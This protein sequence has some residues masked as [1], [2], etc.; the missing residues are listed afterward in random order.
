[1][2][3]YGPSVVIPLY[4]VLM[5]V[6]LASTGTRVWIR[7]SQSRDSLGIDDALII[8]G[9][10][11]MVAVNGMQYYNA[12]VGTGGEAVTD[13]DTKAQAVV[14]SRKIDW[15]M[16]VIEKA[17]FGAVKLSFLFFY[18]RIFNVWPTFRRI[19]HALM[20]IVFAWALAFMISDILICGTHPELIW[21]YD[22][23]IARAQCGNR[24]A[25]LL[26]FSVT[27]VATDIAVLTLPIV[28]IGRLQMSRKSK[29][30][31]SMVFLCGSL[32][33]GASILRMIFLIVSYPVGRLGFAYSPPPQEETPLVLKA[34]NPTEGLL[35]SL[36]S[37][38]HYPGSQAI[39][40]NKRKG[41]VYS[42]KHLP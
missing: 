27:S 19:N 21:G 1:M 4:S 14:A 16:I 3:L 28:Y 23:T 37:V 41:Y 20:A 12:L 5:A 2:S 6:G 31:A 39:I 7:V 17:A 25:Q 13:P 36:F 15:S 33:T 11:I 42:G 22:Q 9:V 24:G 29:L 26:A 32:S 18:R 30:A 8:A 10:V 35:S 38:F 40:C 34:F